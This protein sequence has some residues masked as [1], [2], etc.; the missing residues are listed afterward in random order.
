MRDDHQ[1][2]EGKITGAPF[3]YLPVTWLTGLGK[4]GKS[5]L[6]RSQ[7]ESRGRRRATPDAVA[8]LEATR[9]D[10]EGS[11]AGRAVYSILHPFSRR[12]VSGALNGEPFMRHL[13]RGGHFRPPQRPSDRRKPGKVPRGDVLGL[14]GGGSR[15]R[16]LAPG[17]GQTR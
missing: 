13:F 5:A 15:S 6:G 11:L 8:R 10:P 7:S 4:V 12:K 9:A 3:A 1:Q 17:R 2:H 14:P 16:H